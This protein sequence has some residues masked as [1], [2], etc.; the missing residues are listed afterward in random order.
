MRPIG[1]ILYFVIFHFLFLFAQTVPKPVL[2]FDRNEILIGDQ[3]KGV[4]GI[5]TVQGVNIDFPQSSELWKS[6]K[7]EVLNVSN[8]DKVQGNDK[9]QTLKQSITLVFWDTGNYVLP[10]LP[11][12]YSTGNGTDTVFSETVLFKVKFPDGITGDSTYLA[13]IKNILEEKK[14]FW[15]YLIDYQYV[16]YTILLIAL[17]AA[18]VYFYFKYRKNAGNKGQLS[19]EERALESLEK[20]LAEEYSQKSQHAL[21]HEGISIIVRTYLNEKFGIRALES[22]SSEIIESLDDNQISASL[23]MELKELLETADLVKFAKASPLAVADK[24]AADY[25][26]KLVNWVI[27]AEKAALENKKQEDEAKK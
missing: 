4:L 10:P 27:E 18:S 20:L 25:I 17:I 23:R 6:E 21:Y 16:I 22:I 8:I 2:S 19:P 5:E 14:T 24:F 3:V 26:R 7:I 9:K 12:T 1:F 11:F 15:D 13:P